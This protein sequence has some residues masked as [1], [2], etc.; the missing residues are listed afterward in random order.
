MIEILDDVIA[1]E[2]ATKICLTRLADDPVLKKSEFETSNI[3]VVDFEYHL[4][5]SR[6]CVVLES[7]G[8][9]SFYIAEILRE[10]LAEENID[11]WVVFRT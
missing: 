8:P 9:L 1:L 11:A 5:T 3:I 10:L 4:S 7:C 2:E 6:K